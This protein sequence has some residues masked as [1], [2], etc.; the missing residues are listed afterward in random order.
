MPQETRPI[1]RLKNFN[2][3]EIGELINNKRKFDNLKIGQN[4]RLL[5]IP[6]TK[7]NWQHQKM[8]DGIPILARNAITDSD[9]NIK[10]AYDNYSLIAN[11]KAGYLGGDITRVYSENI[12]EQLKEKYKEFDRTNKTK[13]F[14]KDLMTTT[15]AY[16]ITY[17]LNFLSDEREVFIK[18]IKPFNGF[19]I[20]NPK[21]KKPE[22][23]VIYSREDE[24]TTNNEQ[25]TRVWIYNDF[26]VFEYKFE[27][28][29]FKL[30]SSKPHGFTKMPMNEWLNN[31]FAIGN[32]EKAISLLDAWDRLTSDNATEWA[33]FRNAYL[34]LKN[35][36]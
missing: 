34:M 32:S 4:N 27:K 6:A 35:M 10:L 2:I 14:W 1:L 11:T 29:V 12:T 24:E 25:I 9:P 33:T 3:N 20:K 31:K 26:N 23:G 13:S 22:I 36:G 30:V 15:S 5:Q 17:S 8:A 18:E 7:F 19:I 28:K 16:G 21:T